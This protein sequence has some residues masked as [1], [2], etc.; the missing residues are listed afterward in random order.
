MSHA[1]GTFFSTTK[2][3]FNVETFQNASLLLLPKLEE[4]EKCI[5]MERERDREREKDKVRA[6]YL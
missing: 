6:L 4:L 5:Y 1:C 2:F 3:V